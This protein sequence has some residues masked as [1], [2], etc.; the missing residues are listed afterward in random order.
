MGV[1]VIALR[2]LLIIGINEAVK[3]GRLQLGYRGLGITSSDD[4]GYIET[5]ILGHKS[6][7]RWSD[8]GHGELQ[9]AVWWKYDHSRHPQANLTGPHQERFQFQKPLANPVHFP[10]FVGVIVGVWLE[11]E[12]GPYLQGYGRDYLETY[13]RRGER[14]AIEELPE[15]KPHGYKAEGPFHI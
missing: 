12:N 7:V 4:N 1:V 5:E 8:G 9:V 10:K 6:I 2:R 11:R 14:S 13:I 15:I 3:Q